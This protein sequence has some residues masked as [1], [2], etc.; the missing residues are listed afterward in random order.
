MMREGAISGEQSK[1]YCRT[2]PGPLNKLQEKVT[3]VNAVHGPKFASRDLMEGACLGNWLD[4]VANQPIAVV[5]GVQGA[6]QQA[7]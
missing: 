2:D 7:M 3:S 4:S 5:H 1:P 6:L